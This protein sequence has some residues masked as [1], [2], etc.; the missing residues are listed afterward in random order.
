MQRRERGKAE[1]REDGFLEF[2]IDFVFKRNEPCTLQ[3]PKFNLK[4][5]ITKVLKLP[6]KVKLLFN[7]SQFRRSRH[8]C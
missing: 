6:L 3:A 5:S 1:E 4:L 7:S 2:E 8:L